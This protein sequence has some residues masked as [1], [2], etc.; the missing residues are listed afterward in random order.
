MCTP[1]LTSSNGATA[2]RW[3][4]RSWHADRARHSLRKILLSLTGWAVVT[5]ATRRRFM[6][7][8]D[9]LSYKPLC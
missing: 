4:S 3:T 6:C 8:S 5:W 1:S 7:F 2:T 9:V